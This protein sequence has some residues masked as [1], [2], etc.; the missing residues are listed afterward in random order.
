MT[1]EPL[2]RPAPTTSA[3]IRDSWLPCQAI[4]RPP[5]SSVTSR[6]PG[7]AA[8]YASPTARGWSGSA[9]SSEATTAA[10]HRQRAQ[11]VDL[12]ERVRAR[13]RVE[14]VGHRVGMIVLGE[15]LGHHPDRG[16]APALGD[17]ARCPAP[18]GTRRRHRCAT[19]PTAR[20]NGAGAPGHRLLRGPAYAGVMTTI[21][22]DALGPVAARTSAACGRPSRRRPAPPARTPAPSSTAS[23]SRCQVLVAVGARSPAPGSSGRGHGRRRRSRDGR[24]AA[25]RSSPSRRSGGL[26]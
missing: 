23:R 4:G 26:R 10:G 15:P 7:I 5:G 24:I 14:R 16:L 22:G 20:P 17:R 25:A 2:S 13:D 19:P 12:A 21:A 3:M 8:A 11:L 6:A 9:S 1:A 18:P